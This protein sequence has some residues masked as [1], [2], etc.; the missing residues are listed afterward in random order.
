MGVSAI[1]PGTRLGP[2]GH[3][4]SFMANWAPLVFY[5]LLDIAPAPGLSWPQA[6]SCHHGPSWPISISPT[7]RPLSLFLGLGVSLCLLGG[8]GPPM[9]STAC[10]PWANQPPFVLIQ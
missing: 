1:Q 7:P 2:I 4:I 3:T 6:I 5:G 9:A 10:G 8:S